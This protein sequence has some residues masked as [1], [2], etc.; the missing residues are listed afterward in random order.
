MNTIYQHIISAKINKEQLLAVLIDPDKVIIEELPDFIR[1]VNTSIATHIFLGGS[2]VE[3]GITHC[4]AITIKKYTTLPIVLFPGDENQI[5]D[6]AD[7]ILFLSLL[8]GRNT[9]YL[10]DQHIRAV[11]KL[12]NSTL[13]IIPTSYLLIDGGKKTSTQKVSNT[14][15][16]NHNDKKLIVNTAV[17]GQFLGHQL[18]Y[19]EA[20]SGAKTPIHT[21]TIEAVFNATSN[22]L[23]V[24]GGI[25]SGEQIQK[26]YTA[27]A[28][29][30][31]IGTAF[32]K[33]VH[34]FEELKKNKLYF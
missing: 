30:V 32:E 11:P 7:G 13:E 16:L 20:G 21:E 2:S 9:E 31:V 8:S 19:L 22:P 28:T 26:A 4:V 23:I 33:D 5:T 10:I 27:G 15:P 3:D 17:A 1:K 18:T 14:E 24:G 34:F 6:V 29:M 12:I 25:A